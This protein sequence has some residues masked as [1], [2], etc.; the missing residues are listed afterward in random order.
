MRSLRFGGGQ[1]GAKFLAKFGATFLAKVSNLF[2]WD[3]RSNK[4]LQ[5]KLQ[6]KSPTPLRSKIEEKFHG[7]VLQGDPCQLK[8]VR[9]GLGETRVKGFRSHAVESVQIPGTGPPVPL[10][11]HQLRL[12]GH[13]F[14]SILGH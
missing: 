14:P 7:E 12:Q 13:L 6:P 5:Q 8:V 3:I 10:Q 4:K 2:C 1:F 11:N 9:R